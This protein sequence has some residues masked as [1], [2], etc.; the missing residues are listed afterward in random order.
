MQNVKTGRAARPIETKEVVGT[1]FSA[2]IVYPVYILFSFGEIRDEGGEVGR[3][4]NEAGRVAACEMGAGRVGWREGIMLDCR[5]LADEAGQ[6]RV[7][8]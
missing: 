6:A 1:C 3:R 2:Q 8:I 4:N 5:N 7:P